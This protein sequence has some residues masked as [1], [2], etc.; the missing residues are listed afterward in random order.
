MIKAELGE[1][2]NY[3]VCLENKKKLIELMTVIKQ[4]LIKMQRENGEI[5][6]DAK[7][8][9]PS[10]DKVMKRESEKDKLIKDK[11]T[12]T[13]S[14]SINSPNGAVTLDSPTDG[15]WIKLQDWST[16]TLKCGGGTQSY[17]R[18][19][20]PPKNNGKPCQ[21][22]SILIHRCNEH[23]CPS[24]KS[25]NAGK[26]KDDEAAKPIVKVMPFSNRYQKYTVSIYLNIYISHNLYYYRN[27]LSKSKMLYG[28]NSF[29]QS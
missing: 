4:A 22:E 28:L 14:G 10:S 21:G 13:I 27:V 25:P 3:V 8:K 26:D 6:L 5:L 19:C 16:C 12:E 9:P 18:M 2:S 11:L 24:I 17:H 7:T 29:L 20:V 15:Y 23:P 1:A